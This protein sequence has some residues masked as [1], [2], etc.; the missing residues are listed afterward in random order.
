MK[1]LLLIT[2]VALSINANAQ[3]VQQV[4]GVTDI[5]S[6]VYFVNTQVGYATTSVIGANYMLKT[7]DGGTTWGQTGGTNAN[8]NTVWFTSI[9]TGYVSKGA[10]V[11][12][13]N[14]G[15]GTWTF[16]ALTGANYSAKL[17]FTS[18]S[19]GYAATSSGVYTG[20][21]F[22]TT[23]RGATWNSI[24]GTTFAQLYGVSFPSADTGY[25]VGRSGLGGWVQKTTDAGLTWT[26]LNSGTS[27]SGATIYLNSVYFIPHTK[28]GYIA[29]YDG[30]TL[31]GILLKTTD[32]TTWANITPAS[33]PEM[34]SVNF[35]DIN[36]GWAVGGAGTNIYYTNDGGLT[37]TTQLTSATDNLHSVFFVD[38]YNGWAVGTS[39]KIESFHTSVGITEMKNENFTIAPN[40]FTSQTTITFNA[41][42]KNTTIKLTDILGK[43]IKT[44][45]FTGR[46][47][48][49]ERGELKEG[50]Y[51]VQ[52]TDEQKHISNTK[53]VIQ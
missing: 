3:W 32:G 4:S 45:N 48:V 18:A 11:Y 51:F 25:V 53:I 26:T 28:V 7:T 5:L 30:S 23:N 1:K 44:I 36:T 50:I 24:T 40:P 33:C 37:W 13:T 8:A 39:G 20:L 35:V 47:L 31:S 42:Q 15:G 22:K 19:T 21:L 52:T 12:K 27:S 49:I 6:D 17:C 38:A 29:G 16:T 14:D 34:Y 46:Q 2:I 10:S 41:E 9:D 43:E